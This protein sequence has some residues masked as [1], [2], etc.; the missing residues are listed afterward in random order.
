MR[1]SAGLMSHSGEERVP[2]MARDV[3]NT[4]N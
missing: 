3:K 1:F 4:F 2:I